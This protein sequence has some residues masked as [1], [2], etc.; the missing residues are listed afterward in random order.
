[1]AIL[2]PEL[3]DETLD[4]LWDDPKALQA[5]SLTCR[6]WVPTARLHLFRTVRLSSPSTCADFASIAHPLRPFEPCRLRIPFVCLLIYEGLTPVRSGQ[7]SIQIHSLKQIQAA[8][9]AA[10]RL[11]G[12]WGRSY[13]ISRPRHRVRRY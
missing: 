8:Q 13:R 9:A 12:F 7:L 10:P 3:F 5:C 2:P 6:A 11:I 4:H 1:M